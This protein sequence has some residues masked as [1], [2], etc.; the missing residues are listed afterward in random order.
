LVGGFS[1]SRLELVILPSSL[2]LL[3]DGVRSG[4]FHPDIVSWH[5]LGDEATRP[6]GPAAP[7]AHQAEIRGRAPRT[8]SS[9]SAMAVLVGVLLSTMLLTTGAAYS[10]SSTKD[11]LGSDVLGGSLNQ[12]KHLEATVSSSFFAPLAALRRKGSPLEGY[13][14]R[15]ARSNRSRFT[16]SLLA[17]SLL[18]RVMLS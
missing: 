11:K 1:L 4:G 15:E 7:L 14:G 8:A 2:D 17:P 10:I 3:P 18:S 9:G 12:K 6:R 13:P 16:N 5:E